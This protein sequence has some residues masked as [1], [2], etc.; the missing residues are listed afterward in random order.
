MKDLQTVARPYAKA[1]FELALKHQSLKEWSDVLTVLTATVED[2]QM[3]KLLAHPEVTGQMLVE[4]L[5]DVVERILSLK[6]DNQLIKDA[7]LVLADHHR[8]A[9]IPEVSRQYEALKNEHAKMCSGTVF[10]SIQL[11]QKQM[12]RLEAGLQ[13]KLNKTV[14]LNQVVQPALLGGAR[15]QIGDMVIDGT[16]RARLQRLS[17][18]L[19]A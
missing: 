19:L 8:L 11:D 4:I 2:V 18:S 14:H 15:V 17:Q 7:L 9:V 10:T 12:Q 1:L 16:L 5:F 6:K 3:Q 13:K